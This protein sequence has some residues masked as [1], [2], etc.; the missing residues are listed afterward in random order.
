MIFD[1]IKNKSNYKS[2]P[3]IYQALDYLT[4]MTSDNISNQT[5]NLIDDILFGNFVS[6]SSKPEEECVF[7]AHKKY[8][9]LHYIIEGIEGIATAD[10]Y[11]LDMSIPYNHRKDIG[12]YEGMKDGL[13]YLKPGQFMVCWP[14]D[15]HKVAIMYE[16]PANIKKIVFKIKL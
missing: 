4:N 16:K 15:A 14:N 8:I 12:F 7:E 1:S 5:I 10:L 13:Y 2:L 9:D 3:H 11:T 6:L